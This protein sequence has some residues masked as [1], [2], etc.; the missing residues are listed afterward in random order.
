M[1][2]QLDSVTSNLARTDQ[3]LSALGS[4]ESLNS[5][6][7]KLDENI[8]VMRGSM[9]LFPDAARGVSALGG[10]IERSGRTIVTLQA[11]SVRQMSAELR[12]TPDVST[13]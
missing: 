3:Q 5:E 13:M 2:E 4:L 1:R 7:S 9:G 12:S 8:V 6:M 11:A 10:Q